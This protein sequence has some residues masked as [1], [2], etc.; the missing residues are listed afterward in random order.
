MS[1]LYSLLATLVEQ[2]DLRRDL[3]LILTPLFIATL[4]GEW[5]ALR[6]RGVFK[7]RDSLASLGLGAIYL[8]GDALLVAFMVLPVYHLVYAARLLD[9]EMTPLAFIALL[10][11]LELCYYGFHRASHRIRWFWAAHVVHHS[12]EHM[13]LTTAMRQSLFYGVAGNWLFYLPLVWLG[14]APEWVLFMLSVSLAYQYF[15]HTQ[16]VGRLP[17]PVE[18]LFNTPSHHRAHHGRNP[19]YIDRNYGGI[20]IIY[21]RLFGTFVEEREPVDYGIVRQVHS[22]NPLWLNL[23]EWVDMFRDVARPGPLALRLK[24]LWA[25]PEWQRPQRSALDVTPR[26]G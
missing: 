22:H 4:G 23:H 9:F 26:R 5:L 21:D 13:N 18:W 20:L 3:L 7:M 10:L 25:P 24:H 15:V 12:S 1:E 8:V 14:F 6:R 11:L 2:I 19:Q 16:G 17:R